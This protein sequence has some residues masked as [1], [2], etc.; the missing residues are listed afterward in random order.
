MGFEV[1]KKLLNKWNRKLR[2]EGLGSRLKP[3]E[4]PLAPISNREALIMLA[5]DTQEPFLAEFLALENKFQRDIIADLEV[6]KEE[7][8]RE[9]DIT[10][11]LHLLV[12]YGHYLSMMSGE[13]SDIHHNPTY[14]DEEEKVTEEYVER[15]EEIARPDT[16]KKPN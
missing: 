15:L 7:G 10:A 1:P 3:E 9:E 16:K 2:Q 5:P 12:K 13:N 8:M 6:K 4:I 14:S 11:R